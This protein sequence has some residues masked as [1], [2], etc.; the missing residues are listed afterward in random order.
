V[1]EL[2][3]ADFVRVDVGRHFAQ[4]FGKAAG[5]VV[6]AEASCVAMR[7]EVG[8]LIRVADVVVW[9]TGGSHTVVETRIGVKNG[10]KNN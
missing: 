6:F 1:L 7:R 4:I 2:F 9:Q 10:K 3:V 5:E 8:R